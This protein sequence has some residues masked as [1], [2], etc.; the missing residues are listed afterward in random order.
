[1]TKT[2]TPPAKRRDEATPKLTVNPFLDSEFYARMR[3][4]TERDAAFIKELKAIAECGAGKKSPDPRYA[5]SLEAL[6]LTVKK[7]LSF[8]EM[9]KR[10][11]EGKEKG[12]WEPWMTTFGIEIRAVNYAPGGPRNACLVLDLGAAAPA[13]AMFAKAGVQNWRSLAADDCAVVR[14]EKATETSP[15]KVFAVFYLD[16]AEK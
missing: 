14:T 9:L 15:L 5:P 6:L 12:L 16:P 1:M 3:D 10:M 11:A 7:G 8:A 4:Y 2:T 13:H